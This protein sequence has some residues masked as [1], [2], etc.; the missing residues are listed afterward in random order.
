MDNKDF[1]LGWYDRLTETQRKIERITGTAEKFALVNERTTKA[2]GA[3]DVAVAINKYSMPLSASSYINSPAFQNKMLI[4][5]IVEQSNR[6]RQMVDMALGGNTASI[7]AMASHKIKEQAIPGQLIS[8]IRNTI[9]NHSSSYETFLT[10]SEKMSQFLTTPK[11]IINYE[12]QHQYFSAK[13]FVENKALNA[14]DIASASTFSNVLNLYKDVDEQTLKQ[15]INTLTTELATSEE[16]KKEVEE[17]VKIVS[18]AT[19]KRS[20]KKIDEYFT[21]WAD[22]IGERFGFSKQKVYFIIYFVGFLIS[23]TAVLKFKDAISPPKPSITY[24]I[25]NITQIINAPKKTGS[26]TIVKDAA[27][28]EKNHTTSRRVGT[29]KQE[30]EIELLKKKDGWC[31]VRGMITTIIKE[32]KVKIPKDTVM[33]CWVNQN[34][35]EYIKY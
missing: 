29:I 13:N 6:S 34:Y 18:D 17:L 23:T 3:L 5:S 8:G 30:I 24:S 28:Y 27:A 31:F 22:R 21:D 4:D 20:Y 14:F 2:L 32:G 26:W 10:A 35:L 11:P 15:N 7:L 19:N 12:D 1:G 25:Q 33:N 16:L 9:L